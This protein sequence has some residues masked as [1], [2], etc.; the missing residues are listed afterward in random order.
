[1]ARHRCFFAWF[2]YELLDGAIGRPKCVWIDLLFILGDDAFPLLKNLLKPYSS[3]QAINCNEQTAFNYRL[4]RA[5]RI[6]ENGFGIFCRHF[7]IFYKPIHLSVQNTKNLIVSACVLHN[8]LR[9][10]NISIANSDQQIQH[11]LPSIDAGENGNRN[12]QIENLE[13]SDVRD[14]FK[15]YFNNDDVLPWQNDILPFH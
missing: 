10:R 6:S 13:A 5:R 2:T 4:C 7:P 11:N 9:S 14:R 8:L 12:N 15:H 1:M 3:Q